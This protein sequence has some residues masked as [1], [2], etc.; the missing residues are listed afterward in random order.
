MLQLLFCSR[1]LDWLVLSGSSSLANIVCK[2]PQCLSGTW[3]DLRNLVEQNIKIQVSPTT[4]FGFVWSFKCLKELFFFPDD[5]QP[6]GP[7]CAISI[8]LHCKLLHA[9]AIQHT[10][11]WLFF[12]EWEPLT[13]SSKLRAFRQTAIACHVM[14]THTPQMCE[15]IINFRQYVK[16]A[17]FLDLLEEGFDFE[18]AGFF[19]SACMSWGTCSM[20]IGHVWSIVSKQDIIQICSK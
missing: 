12:L 20:N 5:F 16:T 3:H 14:H 2:L 4:N 17:H 15:G 19:G 7:S 11:H 8:A 18:A 6:L 13:A 1:F 9:A 10:G